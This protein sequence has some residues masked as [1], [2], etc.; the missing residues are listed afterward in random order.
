MNS[1]PHHPQ[2]RPGSVSPEKSYRQSFSLKP[3]R[4]SSPS[5]ERK[6][7]TPESG[8]GT[9]RGSDSARPRTPS[10]A[11]PPPCQRGDSTK[12]QDSG[13]LNRRAPRG[14]QRVGFLAKWAK[15]GV[16]GLFAGSGRFH[17]L[18]AKTRTG[19]WRVLK[20]QHFKRTHHRI[21]LRHVLKIQ[22]MDRDRRFGNLARRPTLRAWP[23][24]HGR[25]TSG[26]RKARCR[27]VVTGGHTGSRK[28]DCGIA[29]RP[30]CRPNRIR[31]SSESRI[32]ECI[33]TAETIST[34][35][36]PANITF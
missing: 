12:G 25:R 21:V 13:R 10:R 35:T 29:A 20:F 19:R 34:I 16:S 11:L 2:K 27:S 18:R 26:R 8:E 14:V 24:V 15:S 9:S 36:P 17:G 4:F 5:F 3:R 28:L 22:Q 30:R 6:T 7:C 23:N 1:P 33:C 32:R 31:C